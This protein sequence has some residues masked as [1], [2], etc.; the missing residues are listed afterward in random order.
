MYFPPAST[1]RLG[2]TRA[3]NL[4][5]FRSA[6][7][8]ARAHSC[9]AVAAR[10]SAS[11]ACALASLRSRSARCA[12]SP[13]RCWSASSAR[14]SLA[15]ARSSA[16]PGGGLDGRPGGDGCLVAGHC[17][18]RAALGVLGERLGVPLPFGRGAAALRPDG[19]EL[20]PGDA[21]PRVLRSASRGSGPLRPQSS[22]ARIGG[23][24]PR[25]ASPTVL[26]VA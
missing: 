17:V 15:V 5:A 18:L 10:V 8:V 19:A 26:G 7:F 1:I 21:P 14:T 20:L 3:P 25:P 9:S 12:R 11:R 13:S 24:G 4:P 6:S 16:L 22:C 23:T 2:T